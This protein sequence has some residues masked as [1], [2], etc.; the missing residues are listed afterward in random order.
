MEHSRLVR[1]VQEQLRP[2]ANSLS[3][4]TGEH[5]EAFSEPSGQPAAE[6]TAELSAW[7]EELPAATDLEGT[8]V[9]NDQQGDLW[10][11]NADGSDHRQLTDSGEGF[12]YSPTWSPADPASLT[13]L[14]R[15]CLHA[16][17]QKRYLPRFCR[18]GS[19]IAPSPS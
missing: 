17:G 3:P 1:P 12:D 7:V 18:P 8:V 15:P 5:P 19:A 9:Y 11:V 16:A 13:A 4:L 14:A 10:I 6:G 2:A